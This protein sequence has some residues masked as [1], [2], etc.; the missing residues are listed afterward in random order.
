MEPWTYIVILGLAVIGYSTMKSQPHKSQNHNAVVHDI[1]TAL[2]QFA[3]ELEDDNEQLL[4][5]IAGLKRELEA[6]IN[7][8]NGRVEAIEKQT[9]QMNL[10]ASLAAL[11]STEKPRAKKIEKNDAH[12]ELPTEESKEPES[13]I[14]TRYTTVF[15]L[16]EQG[17]SIEYIA[18]KTGMNKGEVQLIIQLARQEEQFR[19]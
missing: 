7:K 3:Q 11:S 19:D 18:K 1:E 12:N 5:S 14:K 2:D 16:H 4:Q 17:K 10:T 15:E 8:L 6:E 9:V 13:N